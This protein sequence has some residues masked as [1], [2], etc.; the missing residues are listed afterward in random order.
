MEMRWEIKWGRSKCNF[1]W[2][3]SIV[4]SFLSFVAIS[5]SFQL[6]CSISFPYL[7]FA[8][9]AIQ[10][11]VPFISLIPAQ[12]SSHLLSNTFVFLC[13]I[14]SSFHM[15]EQPMMIRIIKTIMFLNCFILKMFPIIQN[16]QNT[17]HTLH[18]F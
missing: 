6:I 16:H 15:N 9:I 14:C 7:P 2:C 5:I 3:H 18:G 8:I 17:Q 10:Y 13:S 4:L 11:A 1:L 12:F